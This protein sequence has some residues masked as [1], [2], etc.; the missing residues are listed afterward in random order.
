MNIK[1]EANMSISYDH[2]I[3]G[4]VVYLRTMCFTCWHL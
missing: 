3:H 1:T 2:N 4:F